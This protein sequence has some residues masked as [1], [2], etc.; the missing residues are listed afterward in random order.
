MKN[1]KPALSRYE[2]HMADMKRWDKM[3]HD[4]NLQPNMFGNELDAGN[5]D[6]VTFDWSLDFLGRHIATPIGGSVMVFILN[7]QN[8]KIVWL[9]NITNRFG[10]FIHSGNG[11][12]PTIK[13]AKLAA[14]AE[15]LR[16][17]LLPLVCPRCRGQCWETSEC[18]PLPSK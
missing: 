7:P 13:D 18:E 4:W 10:A 16:L 15:F 5:G 17:S 11:K 14:E 8:P 6:G 12:A 1:P 3:A 2:K 9:A